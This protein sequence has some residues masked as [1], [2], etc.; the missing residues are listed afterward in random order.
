VSFLLIDRPI[1][2]ADF[3]TA[4]VE[5]ASKNPGSCYGALGAIQPV[6]ALTA[7][8]EAREDPWWQY[9]DGTGRDADALLDRLHRLFQGGGAQ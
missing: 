4:P 1:A 9:F 7:N 2:F 6:L 3:T 5:P 8:E